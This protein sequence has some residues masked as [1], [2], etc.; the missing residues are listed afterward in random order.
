MEPNNSL[1]FH[2][3]EMFFFWLKFQ[4][5]LSAL[6]KKY[7]DHRFSLTCWFQ[8]QGNCNSLSNF[9]FISFITEVFL[10]RLKGRYCCVFLF[11]SLW[12]ASIFV[13]ALNKGWL[14]AW[15]EARGGS[16]IITSHAGSADGGRTPPLQTP[17]TFL[18]LSPP[19]HANRPVVI[20]PA[21]P[22]WLSHSESPNVGQPSCLLRPQRWAE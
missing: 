10:F 12:Y 8:G 20:P 3:L 4:F 2:V 6:W 18:G 7:F 22:H 19:L 16:V 15:F 9:S 21:A 13:I 11:L 14:A 1:G 17:I 5:S